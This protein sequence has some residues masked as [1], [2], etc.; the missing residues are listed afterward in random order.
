MDFAGRDQIQ[1]K[2][3][4]RYK[5]TMKTIRYK[6]LVDA[7]AQ[8]I[9]NGRLRP[10]ERLPTHRSLAGMNRLALATASRVYA[11]LELMGLVTG[12]TGR[13]T[14]VRARDYPPDSSRDLQL[15]RQGAID[16]NFSSPSIPRQTD[17]LRDA[18]RRL[19]GAGDLE[20][21][22]HYQP[23][24]G[25]THER[26]IVARHLTKRGL[27]IPGSQVAIVNGAQ[28]GLAVVLMSLLQPGQVIAVDEL[29]YAG[30]KSLAQ[31]LRIELAPVPLTRNGLDTQQL[32]RLCRIRRIRALYVMPTLH[33]PLGDVMSL[34]ARQRLVTIARRHDLLI[35]EDAAYAFLVPNPPPPVAALAAERTLY[36]SSLSKSIGTGLRFGFVAAPEKFIG[37]I[38]RAI[39]STTSNVPALISS[40]ACAWIEDG[41]VLKLE[42]EKRKDAAARQSIVGR[43]FTGLPIRR[44]PFSYFAWLP[45]GEDGRSNSVAAALAKQ[46]ISVATAEPFAVTAHI[47]R[48]I[49]LA[50]G[51]VA[52]ATLEKALR[53]VRSVVERDGLDV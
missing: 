52:I 33:N 29:T 18:L 43:V 27:N 5:F 45:L 32:E 6:R 23:Y 25:R 46:G 30:F 41:T 38:E 42:V 20:P 17:L 48:A 3:C 1:S 11:E 51:S 49:R 2:N 24:L 13:G 19:A 35:I 44:H 28:H 10:G 26:E 9:R 39:R 8:D 14:F 15:P 7:F 4:T 34:A 53:Q 16:F 40:I 47:P 12:E 31:T 37:P 50:L 36:V 22:L 21:S